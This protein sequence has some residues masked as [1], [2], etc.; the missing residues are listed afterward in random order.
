MAL[1]PSQG[2]GWDLHA[3]SLPRPFN[4][5]VGRCIPRHWLSHGNKL[6]KCHSTQLRRCTEKEVS[7]AFLKG[8]VQ[9]SVLTSVTELTNN[10]SPGQYADLS[11]DLPTRNDLRFGEGILRYLPW[12]RKPLHFLM[13]RCFLLARLSLSCKTC[14]V[15][16]H[17]Y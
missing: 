9:I 16:C 15:D 7:I 10:L 6:I 2:F 4:N 13:Y 17:R 12:I 1:H 5:G 14:L 3:S 11:F 8:L